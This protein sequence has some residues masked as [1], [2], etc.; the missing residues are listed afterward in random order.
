M[1]YH[2]TE[3]SYGHTALTGGGKE[4]T[5]SRS[6][7]LFAVAVGA[8]VFRVIFRLYR[9]LHGIAWIRDQL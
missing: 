6:K 7:R 3:S 4:Q 1:P 9:W 2:T 5:R 8:F